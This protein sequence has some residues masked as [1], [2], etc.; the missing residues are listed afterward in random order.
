[1]WISILWFEGHDSWYMTH[2]LLYLLKEICSVYLLY[3]TRLN[4]KMQ[5][6]LPFIN[7]ISFYFLHKQFLC[8]EFSTKKRKKWLGNHWNSKLLLKFQTYLMRIH[9]PVT[10]G[11]IYA[12]PIVLSMRLNSIGLMLT[13]TFL[14]LVLLW[15]IVSYLEIHI[16][17]NISFLWH[18]FY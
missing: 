16:Y 9:F 2:S 3:A 5:C 6:I 18:R 14:K 12:Y 11:I 15:H 4:I 8:R 7:G 1:M 17:E 13:S 10:F